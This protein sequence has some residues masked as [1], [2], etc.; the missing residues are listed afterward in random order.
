MSDA[1]GHSRQQ[2]SDRGAV[3]D[4][5]RSTLADVIMEFAAPLLALDPSGATDPEVMGQVMF[6]VDMCWNLPVLEKSDPEAYARMKHGF[7]TV[8]SDLPVPIAQQLSALLAD[9]ATRFAAV[10]FL[11]QTRVEADSTGKARIVTEARR[12]R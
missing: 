9:R 12:P 2:S 6:L 8:M 5:K 10:P 4:S 11:V 3:S 7:D 1:P